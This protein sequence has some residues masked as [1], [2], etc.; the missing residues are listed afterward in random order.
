MGARVPSNEEKAR[1]K[2]LREG[3]LRAESKAQ[4]A[5]LPPAAAKSDRGKLATID[6]YLWI[7]FGDP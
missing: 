4:A 1:R 2:G 3:L 7:A 5:L 6:S